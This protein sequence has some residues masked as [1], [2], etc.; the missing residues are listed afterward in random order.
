MHGYLI[1]LL[2]QTCKTTDSFHLNCISYYL[3]CSLRPKSIKNHLNVTS[4]QLNVNSRVNSFDLFSWCEKWSFKMAFDIFLEFVQNYLIEIR[5]MDHS[6]FVTKGKHL[7]NMI[8]QKTTNPS[9]LFI[10]LVNSRLVVDG[11]KTILNDIFRLHVN[12]SRDL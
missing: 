4:V 1:K 9:F 7:H 10:T 3:M 11:W 12:D 2:L 8:S 6:V 5:W